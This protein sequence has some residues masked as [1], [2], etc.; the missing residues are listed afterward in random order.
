M[1]Y[2]D[3]RYC[4]AYNSHRWVSYPYYISGRL[5]TGSLSGRSDGDRCARN[6][7]RKLFGSQKFTKLVAGAE[8]VVE[9]HY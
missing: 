4:E 5:T 9:R 3:I 8:L 2:A 1:L 7:N 6:G